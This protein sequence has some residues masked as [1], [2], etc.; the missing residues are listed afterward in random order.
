MRIFLARAAQPLDRKVAETE[1]RRV[2]L[3]VLAREDDR[4]LEAD[5]GERVGDGCQLDRFGPGAN[6]QP[7]LYAIQSSP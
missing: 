3:G 4:R 7:N 5:F 2:Q 6:D 1:F